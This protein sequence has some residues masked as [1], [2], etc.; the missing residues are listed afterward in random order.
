MIF[1]AWDRVVSLY[2][3]TTLLFRKAVVNN[4]L[5][6]E[7]DHQVRWRMAGEGWTMIGDVNLLY[8]RQGDQ[9][10]D[11]DP[12]VRSVSDDYC[13]TVML[14][15]S[16]V[17]QDV[18]WRDQTWRLS[19]CHHRKSVRIHF[20]STTLNA[21]YAVSRNGTVEHCSTDNAEEREVVRQLRVEAVSTCS[22]PLPFSLY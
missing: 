7:E 6:T 12:G 20:R 4:F 10:L 15:G 22:A 1:M 13:T 9:C 2:G 11:V 18:K 21:L 5:D 16:N 8:G 14:G 19:Y 17:L 3:E